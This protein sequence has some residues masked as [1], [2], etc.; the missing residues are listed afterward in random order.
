L[1]QKLARISL[2]V[3][4]LAVLLPVAAASAAHRAGF[5]RWYS[6]DSPFNQ[7][8]ASGAA[9]D[10][11]SAAMVDRLVSGAPGGF[12]IGAKQ[13]TVPVWYAG[14]TTPRVTVKLTASWAP[15]RKLVGVPIPGKAKPDPAGD[16]HMTIIDRSTG[17]EYDFWQAVHNTDGSW[18][19]SWGNATLSTGTGVYAG[20]W[21]T[22]A[23]GFANG[24]GKIRPEELAAG[25]IN[26]ALVFGFPYTKEG[27]P[28][29][30]ATSS[31]GHSTASGAIPEGARLQLDP[32]LDLAS[33]GLNAWQATIA[34][35]LQKFGM[36]LGDTGGTVGLSAVNAISFPGT[37]YPWGDVSYAYLP[38]SLLQ[39]MRVL[40]LG[41]QYSPKGQLIQT[42]CATLTQ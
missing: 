15:A 2:A 4:A 31:D 40:K 17:C 27:G 23:A 10:P 20:G 8:I 29:L 22:T 41:P 34:R 36:I 16:H 11:G 14:S 7:R 1:V 24:L 32:S 13:W 39:H 9:V 5:V 21:A 42:S 25:S 37:P 6:S 18:S 28:V 3:T 26:H 38:T 12:A 33:L 35:A 30:P 19:A